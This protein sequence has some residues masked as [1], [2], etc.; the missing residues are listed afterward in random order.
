MKRLCIFVLLNLAL[1]GGGLAQ[2]WFTPSSGIGILQHRGDHRFGENNR[3]AFTSSLLRGFG[4]EL[5]VHLTRDS[6]LAVMHDKTVDRTTD[7]RGFISEKSM[8]EMKELD[9]GTGVGAVLELSELLRLVEKLGKDSQK[10]AVQIKAEDS[11]VFLKT[12]VCAADYLRNSNVARR[13][14]LFAVPPKLVA[15]LRAS[16]GPDIRLI[17]AARKPSDLDRAIDNGADGVWIYFV[18]TRAFVDKA[19]RAGLEVVVT[20]QLKENEPSFNPAFE[21]RLEKPGLYKELSRAGV[22]MI[23]T[24]YPE[25]VREA[26]R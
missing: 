19:H 26:L 2:E 25:S 20:P 24:D 21:Y 1:A 15:P 6:R 3:D 7:G 16:V 5:D 13:C 4:I 10:V 17:Q 11:A 23:C 8:A 14:F 12:A 18:P 22:D 9:D